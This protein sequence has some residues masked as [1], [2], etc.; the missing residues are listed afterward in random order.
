MR[1]FSERYGYKSPKEEFQIDSMDNDLRISLWNEVSQ[2][3][4]VKHKTSFIKFTKTLWKDFFKLPIDQLRT[5]STTYTYRDLRDQFTKLSWYEI[6]D[7]VEFIA[8]MNFGYSSVLDRFIENCNIILQRENSAYRFANK[9][10][11]KITSEVEL[12]E[13]EGALRIEEPFSV[14]AVHLNDSLKFLSDRKSPN[15]RNSIKESIS[16]V[17]S[18]VQI[19]IGEEKSTL[20]K[21]LKKIEPELHPALKGAFEKLYGYTSNAEGIRHA[22]IEEPNLDFED[23]KFMLVSCSAFINYL[24]IKVT[25][26]ELLL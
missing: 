26:A 18:M 12:A 9:I 4:Y 2:Y 10:L 14:V 3:F 21:A 5:G 13:V 22:L 19:I 23:A 24:K 6:Y 25:K 7:F 1:R 11:T 20:G 17:E 16:A 15:Y 8:N